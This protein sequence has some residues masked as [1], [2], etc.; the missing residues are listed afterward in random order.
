[1]GHADFR[2]KSRPKV[3]GASLRRIVTLPTLGQAT[4]I[5][6]T[7]VL[8][9]FA[10]RAVAVSGSHLG[11]RSQANFLRQWTGPASQMKRQGWL[12]PDSAARTTAAFAVTFRMTGRT[13]RSIRD[14]SIIRNLAEA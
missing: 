5:R 9:L 6:G 14:L 4:N 13:V 3:D 10:G 12:G 1:V 11:F 8:A 7:A 2:S